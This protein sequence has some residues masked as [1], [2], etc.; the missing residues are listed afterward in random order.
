[1]ESG[2]LRSL[3][4]AGGASTRAA[5][6]RARFDRGRLAMVASLG[7]WDEFDSSAQHTGTADSGGAGRPDERARGRHL[8]LTLTG[9]KPNAALEER[10]ERRRRIPEAPSRR[11]VAGGV[12]E[13]GDWLL[14]A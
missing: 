3:Q 9:R 10:V 1:M 12:S 4:I 13:R 7:V 2:M 8:P 11:R 5:R 14:R 6:T